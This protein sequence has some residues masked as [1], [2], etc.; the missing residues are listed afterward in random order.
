[1]EEGKRK[2]SLGR[3]VLAH[4]RRLTQDIVGS[5]KAAVFFKV[6]GDARTIEQFGKSIDHAVE[7]L[8]AVQELMKE[9]PRY[10]KLGDAT[11]AKWELPLAELSEIRRLLS[12][13]QTDK[14]IERLEVMGPLLAQL[15]EEGDR[16][17]KPFMDLTK[18]GEREQKNARQALVLILLGLL[19]G[20]VF[21]A[22]L[23]VGYFSK[24]I[25][26]RLSV[27][28]DN[29]EK[30]EKGSELNQALGGGDE[31]A[32]LDRVFHKMAESIKYSTDQLKLSEAQTRSVIESMPIGVLT[33]DKN[34][35]I[36]SA[37]PTAQK[38]FDCQ[39]SSLEELELS[40]LFAAE[41]KNLEDFS[42]PNKELPMRKLSGDTFPAELS[43]SPLKGPKFEGLLI[44]VVDI[45]A[46]KRAEQVKQEFM[47]MVSHDLR[48]PLASIKLTFELFAMG[49]FGELSEAASKKVRVDESNCRRLISLI[50]DLLDI[51]KLDSGQ[52]DIV[53]ENTDYSTVV[54]NSYA[55]VE[56]LANQ[57][58]VKLEKQVND[59]EFVADPDRIVQV[60]IN[61]LSN[62]I[63]FSP[64][65]STV[66]VEAKL[67]D[68]DKWVVFRVIDQGRGIPE[69]AIK[70]IF[71]K[72]KQV[73]ADD[74]RKKGG[75][76]LGLAICKGLIE[77][78]S[79][80]IGVESKAGEG[81][82]FW[83]KLPSSLS[84]SFNKRA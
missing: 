68:D 64:A 66:K 79:G 12:T 65:D 42:Q 43:V 28:M 80:E 13:G 49:A 14:G 56:N 82:C 75:T 76:G 19:G 26:K 83:F 18:S 54:E 53:L 74:G 36:Q 11:R 73:S 61:L 17:L 37:N 32:E 5:A 59:L 6:S 29:T 25:V 3:N 50:N 77:A 58:K 2:E 33:V 78:H 60:L 72:F 7:E 9:N 52:F 71:D 57:A 67:E 21:L 70:T 41:L 30:L 8:A 46:R 24:K 44:N 55:A 31:I 69:S 1:M 10:K 81:S 34:K 16:M 40:K 48:S 20:S 15:N 35:H 38:M 47:A 23:L 45:T 22:F 62:A 39:S 4:A 51:E 27:L 63:K 84:P